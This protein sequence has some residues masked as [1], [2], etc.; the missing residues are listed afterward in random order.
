MAL[1][2]KG[3][4]PHRRLQVTGRADE[5]RHLKM[6]LAKNLAFD[7]AS[8]YLRGG[9]VSPEQ[10]IPALDIC[11]HLLEVQRFEQ[12]FELLHRNHFLPADIDAPQDGD[13]GWHATAPPPSTGG[14]P[15]QSRSVPR[16]YLP[17]R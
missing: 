7:L 12:A 3:V 17:S 10:H 11:A 13:V 5:D 1:L 16:Q 4:V 9:R 2:Q 15:A 14:S 6:V 8:Q